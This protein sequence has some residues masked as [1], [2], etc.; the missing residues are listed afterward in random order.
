M[1]KH[2]VIWDF[3]DEMSTQEKKQ[4]ALKIKNDVEALA[5]LKG[6]ISLKIYLNPE[7]GSN[8]DIMV[9]STFEDETAFKFY[10]EHPRHIPVKNFIGS[11]TKSR[12]CF[13]GSK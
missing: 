12:K 1:F 5:D 4:T 10:A 11:V 13:D 6:V 3:K 8:C 7:L 2:I 9:D